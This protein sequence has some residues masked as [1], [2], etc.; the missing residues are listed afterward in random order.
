MGI[1]ENSQ[2]ILERIAQAAE[3]AGRDPAGIT[4]VAVTKTHP[5]EV[6]EEAWEA[7]LRHFGENRAHELADKAPWLADKLGEDHGIVWHFIGH[8][9][10]RQSQPISDFGHMFHA[11]DR[12][13]IISRLDRQL[14]ENG[15]NLEILLEVNISG[16]ASKGG[17]NCS[18]WE[19]SQE[20]QQNLIDAVKLINQSDHLKTMGL[21]TMAP[22]GVESDLIRQVFK[23]TRTLRDRL[24]AELNLELPV[25]SMGMT[26]DFEIAIEEGATHVR[27]GRALFGDRT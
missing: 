20:Q 23:R 15:R 2:E 9:Q 18:H 8:L 21:M 6:L 27:V 16:E 17:F 14:A 10:T 4:L 3:R 25:L 12:P 1:L 26:D 13:K 7:G 5:A 19:N 11:A 24:C 22:W